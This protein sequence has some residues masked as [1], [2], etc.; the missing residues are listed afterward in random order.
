MKT[1]RA[2]HANQGVRA[3]YQRQMLALIE[4]MGA[5]IEYWLKATYRNSPP[6][7]AS[8][9]AKSPVKAVN[10]TLR[11]LS[12]RWL[13]RFDDAA[14]RIAQTYLDQAFRASNTSM[15]E[16]LKE[17]GF[18]V[19]FTITPAVRDAFEASLA[20]NISLIRSIPEQYLSDVEG[21][22]NRAYGTGRDLATI[23]AELRDRYKVTSDRAIL[24]ARD[25]SN[26][27]NAV[28]VQT[29]QMELGLTKA[30]WM[31]SHAG[32]T[33]RP[34]HLAANGKEFE[35]AK[36]MYLDGKWVLPGQEINCRCTSR[37]V[38]PDLRVAE[39]LEMIRSD[40]KRR[41]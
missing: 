36:G 28:V 29:R 19:E 30:I 6:L 22:V 33:P 13:R 35:I 21:I 1:L 9:A 12:V 39:N 8:D 20:E 11:D 4:E 7:L 14:P 25:Q 32:K 5:S 16:A 27:A 31:H 2:V 37:A 23:V 41:R 24:I 15:R 34:S 10:K 17:A 18:A 26:K 38:I 3:K 40:P